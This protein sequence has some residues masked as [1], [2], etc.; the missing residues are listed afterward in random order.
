MYDRGALGGEDGGN[1]VVVVVE[2]E[3]AVAGEVTLLLVLPVATNGC[4]P[5]KR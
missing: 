1:G 4:A 3:V 5:W 2:A